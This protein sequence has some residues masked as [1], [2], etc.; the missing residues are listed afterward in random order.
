[1]LTMSEQARADRGLSLRLETELQRA[2]AASPAH[3]RASMWLGLLAL[4]RENG[5]DAVRYLDEAY[6]IAPD[7]PGLALRQGMAHDMIGDR[8]G[9]IAA[10]RRALGE[11]EDRDMAALSLR[12]LQGH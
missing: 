6:R 2:R 11:D 7:M 9:A 4:N 5:R 8:R 12:E 1:M 10:F 3:A